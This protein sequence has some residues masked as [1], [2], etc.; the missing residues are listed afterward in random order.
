[1]ENGSYFGAISSN[2]ATVA[3]AKL[4]TLNLETDLILKKVPI[5][6]AGVPYPNIQA[7]FF[8]KLNMS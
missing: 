8:L 1:M 4:A 3:I 6:L 7:T 2:I 5:L